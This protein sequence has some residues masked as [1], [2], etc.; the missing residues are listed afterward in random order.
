MKIALL[1]YINR[2]GSTF[3]FEQL[4]RV[5]NILVCPEADILVNL[6]LV[7]PNDLIK[8]QETLIEAFTSDKKLKAWHLDFRSFAFV[9]KTNFEIFKQIIAAYREIEN[10]N[11]TI[12]FF[13]AERLFQLAKTLYTLKQFGEPLDFIGIIRDIRAIYNSQSST[14][15]P[16]TGQHFSCN[17]V[18]CARYWNKFAN[19][20]M[21]D[22]AIYTAVI[23]YSDLIETFPDPLFD[24]IKTIGH[25]SNSFESE[26]GNLYQ[27]ISAD[28]KFLHNHIVEQPD[29]SRVT[30]WKNLLNKKEIKLLELSSD[31][32]LLAYNY[33]LELSNFRSAKLN[34]IFVANLVFYEVRAFLQKVTYHII[35]TL[36][37]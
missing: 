12:V 22:R 27:R 26:Q 20:L 18:A 11:A 8:G 3:L 9:G 1:S 36:N 30:R 37:D 14:I 6:L 16:Q 7:K 19:A 10:P 32:Q 35:K 17:P 31:K 33:K 24:L 4:S 2:S 25:T 13:K 5:K 15:N 21:E 23:K 29:T 34:I 28:H